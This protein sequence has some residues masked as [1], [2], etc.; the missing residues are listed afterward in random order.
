MNS[1]FL[2]ILDPGHGG[3]IDG[4]YQTSGKRSPKFDDG[5]VFYE[6]E[7]NRVIVK[8]LQEQLEER[9]IDAIDI[10][11]SDMDV[12]L[13]ERVRRANELGRELDC[14]YISIHHDAF[15]NGRDWTSPSGMSVYTSKGETKSDEFA[16]HVM[17]ELVCQFG[18]T[19]KYRRDFTDG[20]SDKEADFYVLRKTSMPAVLCELGF[21]T[22]KAECER[23]RAKEFKQACVTAIIDAIEIFE[24]INE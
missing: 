19:M 14:V 24:T 20:D 12:S 3:V 2:Y 6:G 18:D 5:Y 8:M 23:M 22:N 13:G 9:G 7:H 4:V 16:S 11:N 1:K 10:V 15:G 21:M 17:Q